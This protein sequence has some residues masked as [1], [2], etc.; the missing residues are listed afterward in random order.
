MT[1][2]LRPHPFCACAGLATTAPAHE[3]P[4]EPIVTAWDLMVLR[5]KIPKLIEMA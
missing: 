2:D 4:D 3:Q 5:M 1:G